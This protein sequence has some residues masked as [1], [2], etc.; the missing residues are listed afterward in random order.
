MVLQ[1]IDSETM[2]LFVRGL[3]GWGWDGMGWEFLGCDVYE[4]CYE[5]DE[6]E[7]GRIG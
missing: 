3:K 1:L 6:M 2:L 5:K 4:Y 7:R